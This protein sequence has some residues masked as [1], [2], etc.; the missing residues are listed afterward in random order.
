MVSKMGKAL[1]L[2]LALVVIATCIGCGGGGPTDEGLTYKTAI[3]F[4][5]SNLEAAIREVIGKPE[6]PIHASE[7]EGLSF[8]T[9]SRRGVTDLTGLEYCTNITHLSLAYNQI[10]DISPLA[11]LINLTWLDLAYN[12]VSNISPLASL[13]NLTVLHLSYN[14]I[15]NLSPLAFLTNLTWLHLG[16][17]QISD[18]ES[19]IGYADGE[20]ISGKDNGRQ[21]SS[22]PLGKLE[23]KYHGRAES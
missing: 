18:G 21:H 2:W 17:N 20:P 4:P 5:D 11:S 10:S 3:A 22:P 8:L 7:L 1:Y 12:Q 16:E 23:E 15:S 13:T 14:Q 9:A 6:G 19:D